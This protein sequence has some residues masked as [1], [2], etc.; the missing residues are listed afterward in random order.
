M[1]TKKSYCGIIHVCLPQLTI[2]RTSYYFSN[3]ICTFHTGFLLLEKFCFQILSSHLSMNE[4]NFILHLEFLLYI[5]NDHITSTQTSLL[6]FILCINCVTPQGFS[7]IMLLFA[8]LIFYCTAEI[9]TAKV[10]SERQK[11]A[12][13]TT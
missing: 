6:I 3:V 8:Q 1:I 12:T 4:I 7:S 11:I 13:N 10:I 2:R 5:K 9:W